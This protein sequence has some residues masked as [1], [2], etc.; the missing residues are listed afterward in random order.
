MKMRKIFWLSV[1]LFISVLSSRLIADDFTISGTVSDESG[2]PVAGAQVYLQEDVLN[3]DKISITDDNGRFTLSLP[4]KC[5]NNSWQ[6]VFAV[7]ANKKQLGSTHFNFEEGNR[8][9]PDFSITLR[10]ARII[11]GNVTDA[12]G[13]PIEG[14]LVAGVDQIVYPNFTKTDKNG[15]FSFAY[16]NVYTKGAPMLLQ[17]VVAFLDN[18]GMDYVCTEELEKYRGKVPPEKIKND[19]FQLKLNNF[20]SYKFRVTDEKGTPLSRVEIWPWLIKK[21]NEKSSYNSVGFPHPNMPSFTGAD[22]TTVVKSIGK[23]TFTASGAEEGIIMPDGSRCFFAY[24]T[25]QMNEFDPAE[26]IPTFVLKRR[27]NVKGSVRLADGTPVAWSRITIKRHDDCGHGLDRTDQNGEFTLR[28]RNANE[29]FDIGVESKLGAA[30]GVF[31]FDVGNGIE[32]KRLDFVLQKGIRLHGTVY[33]PDKTPAEN[34]H[35]SIHEKCPEDLL[36]T[37]Q[38]LDKDKATCPPGGC[39]TGVVIRQQSDY[40]TPNSQG[41]YEYLLPSV[42]RKYNIKVSLRNDPDLILNLTDYEVKGDENEILLDFHLKPK[43]TK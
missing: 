41:K 7:S 27:G 42:P 15:D 20:E 29:L 31:G 8:A 38:I 1:V 26:S 37:I 25:K 9:I 14:V 22:G 28:W 35:I 17:E 36:A 13:K 32:E 34:Y 18:V 33:K 6:R 30:A 10:P 16:P 40:S 12:D 5:V 24:T 39:P 23:T 4:D 3:Q 21:E 11:T 2:K 43:E 19:S